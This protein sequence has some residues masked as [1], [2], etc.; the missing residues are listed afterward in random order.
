MVFIFFIEVIYFRIIH[1]LGFSEIEVASKRNM[2]F[3][4]VL[5]SVKALLDGM[6]KLKIPLNSE[7]AR[8][9]ILY[10]PI[11]MELFRRNFLKL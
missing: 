2:V 5:Q 9:S 4:N 1:N 6:Y 10:N 3:A 11:I 7:K 8:V